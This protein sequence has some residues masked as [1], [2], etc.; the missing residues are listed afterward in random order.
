MSDP[1]MNLPTDSEPVHLDDQKILIDI[2]PPSGDARSSF[3]LLL[4]DAKSIVLSG[5]L[6]AILS[7]PHV[8]DIIQ[9]LIPY[10]KTSPVA[11]VGVKT[12]IFVICIFIYSNI[13][14]IKS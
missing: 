6:F 5:I 13:K 1:I 12:A 7:Y 3:D 9:D 14:Y 8:N 4:R 10:S 11:L 2:I